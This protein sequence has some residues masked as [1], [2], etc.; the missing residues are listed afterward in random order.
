[1]RD[2]ATPLRPI[3]DGEIGSTNDQ[4]L[5]HAFSERRAE[6][7]AAAALAIVG[8][9][10]AWQSTRLDLGRVGLPG[11]GFFPLLLGVMLMVCAGAIGI[12]QW[13]SSAGGTVELGH[14]DVLITVA[15][16]LAVPLLFEPLGAYLTLG[17][18]GGAMLVLVG[19]VALPLAIA[20]AVLA[21]AACWGF[22]QLLLGLQLP[23]GQW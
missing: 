5:P 11:P 20:A 12:G 18:F 4:R 23:A 13:R 15:C 8:A 10:F 16:L 14:R 1:M 3:G 19:R 22:F 6:M 2:P 9:L 21:M 7:L 17:L